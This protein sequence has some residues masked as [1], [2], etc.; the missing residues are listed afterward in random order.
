[1]KNIKVLWETSQNGHVQGETDIA[2]I[3]REDKLY[4]YDDIKGY[5]ILK[6]QLK[7]DKGICI[8]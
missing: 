8:F 5:E 3:N 4:Y 7:K 6:S 1:M 2:R